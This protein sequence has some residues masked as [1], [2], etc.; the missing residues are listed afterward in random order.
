MP[1]KTHILLGVAHRQ[2]TGMSF[3]KC[4]DHHTWVNF[5]RGKVE[6]NTVFVYAF[7]RE[8]ESGLGP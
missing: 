3:D 6:S 1:E 2:L 8:L 7:P 5:Q 4:C